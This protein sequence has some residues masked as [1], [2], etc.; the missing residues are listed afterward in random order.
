MK[1]C[2]C[3]DMC[4]C[5]RPGIMVKE[6]DQLHRAQDDSL[7]ALQI[8]QIEGCMTRVLN[9]KTV[10]EFMN[11]LFIEGYKQ[12]FVDGFEKGKEDY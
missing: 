10:E 1:D 6:G 4:T 3:Q 2:Q 7:S 9:T 12:G 11:S 5:P 8:K